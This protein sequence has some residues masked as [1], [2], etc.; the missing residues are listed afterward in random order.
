VEIV[1]S[2]K[3]R[4]DGQGQ[5]QAKFATFAPI[6]D[7]QRDTVLREAFLPHQGQRVPLVWS[8][9]WGS[10]PIGSGTIQVGYDSALFDGAFH[11][12]TQ[13]SRDAYATVKALGDLQEYSYGFSVP[14]DGALFETA[15][16]GGPV[17][18]ITKIDEIFEVSPVL[19]AA[20]IGTGTVSVKAAGVQNH[21][22]EY[23]EYWDAEID[24]H[25][26]EAA[27]E[28]L[29]VARLRL[30]LQ[31]TPELRWVAPGPGGI[32]LSTGA[33]GWYVPTMAKDAIY[34]LL[35]DDVEQVIRSV[36]HELHHLADER[37]DDLASP[38][39]AAN[40]VQEQAAEAFAQAVYAAVVARAG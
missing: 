30:G 29:D 17:R 20:S 1:K 15:E 13:F 18:V 38:D 8:H 40:A 4:V 21:Y 36:S 2:F 39:S 25:V 11:L 3:A 27:A 37:R 5:L 10:M 33:T 34:V 7:R 24:P 12:E 16:D 9:D 6:I 28:A 31:R 23:A 35:T 22:D 32:R 26:L 14:E 19:V